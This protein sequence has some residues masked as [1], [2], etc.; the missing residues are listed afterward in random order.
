MLLMTGIT[1][2]CNN[3]EEHCEILNLLNSIIVILLKTE[4]IDTINYICRSFSNLVMDGN[5]MIINHLIDC[6]IFEKVVA[7]FFDNLDYFNSIESL[8]L[9]LGFLNDLTFHRYESF[10]THEFKLI[11]PL[12]YRFQ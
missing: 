4:R 6:T 11:L 2:H 8:E 5:E 7:K 1:Y 10:G 12:L 3:L 9:P